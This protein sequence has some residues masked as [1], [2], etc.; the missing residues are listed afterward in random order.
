MVDDRKEIEPRPEPSVEVIY[1]G[2][3]ISSLAI[4]EGYRE[5]GHALDL[6]ERLQQHSPD[7]QPTFT[8]GNKEVAYTG[9]SENMNEV[10]WQA[11]DEKTEAALGRNPK[12][13]F[14]THGTDTMEQTARH[15]NDVFADTLGRKGTKIILTGAND[16]LEHPETDAWDNLR[17]GLENA[18]ADLEPGV[19][20]AFHG[21]LIPADEV[22][23]LPYV[24]GGDVTFISRDDPLYSQSRAQQEAAANRLIDQLETLYGEAPQ[25]SD[26]I[27]YNANTIRPNHQELLDYASEHPVRAL[28][29]T[30]YHSGTANTED[31]QQSVAN[32]VRYLRSE[33]G[34]VSFGVTE[35]GE[36]VDLHAYET[37]IKLRQAGVV[38][39][40]DMP[41]QTA[42]AKLQLVDPGL[43]GP[44]LI[45]EMLTPR[46]GELDASRIISSDVDEL[47]NLY[48]GT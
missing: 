14:I 38:P 46:A 21:R 11:I 12:G 10:Y 25:K 2:G 5:G 24:P 27:S 45:K 13:V 15:L 33:K 40:Y 31:E 35:N 16:D 19:Y 30:L 44:E 43:K 7:F 20:V 18:A 42:W 48:S 41:G 26:I 6:V 9:L 47:L 29:L 1:A 34:I 17:F 8:L 39:L 3:T 32:L 36:P 22:V 23:K 37:S 4:P 28:L